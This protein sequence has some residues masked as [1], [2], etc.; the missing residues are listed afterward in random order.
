MGGREAQ[1]PVYAFPFEAQESAQLMLGVCYSQT[2][3]CAAHGPCSCLLPLINVSFAC[4]ATPRE[5]W[6]LGAVCLSTTT[7][8]TICL[9]DSTEIFNG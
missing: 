5:E 7:P 4:C 1:T 8:G 2:L 9:D 6:P 3:I